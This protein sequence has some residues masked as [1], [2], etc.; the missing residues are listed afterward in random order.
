M[1]VGRVVRPI[2]PAGSSCEIDA[3]LEK[4]FRLVSDDGIAEWLWTHLSNLLSSLS[5]EHS[6]SRS[7][8]FRVIV[9]GNGHFDAPWEAGAH[10]LA[11]ASYIASRLD[12]VVEMQDPCFS[13]EEIGWLNDKP[14]Y[15]H[16]TNV[17]KVVTSHDRTVIFCIHAP[18]TVLNNLLKSNWTAERLNRMLLI[19]ND[20][21]S[22]NLA[23][24]SAGP[25]G[26]LSWISCYAQRCE[27]TPLPSYS[28]NKTFFHDTSVSFWPNIQD[29]DLRLS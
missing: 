19:G 29:A 20:Y 4:A 6:S 18:H 17:E 2:R 16:I 5:T 25:D 24:Q 13:Q 27:S 21:K 22:V 15:H 23:T 26:D 11:V 3:A 9:L 1:V 7:K 28:L 12:A 14:G 8:S 10:Q